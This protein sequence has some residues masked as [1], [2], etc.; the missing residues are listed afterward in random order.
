MPERHK[1]DKSFPRCV[2]FLNTDDSG[3]WKKNFLKIILR[4]G[5]LNPVQTFSFLLATILA[6]CCSEI[7]N[8]TR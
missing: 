5:I 1:E 8:K 6:N 4:K 3:R 2:S 7:N